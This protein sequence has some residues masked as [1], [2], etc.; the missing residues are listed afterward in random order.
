MDPQYLDALVF[1][2]TL[3][4]TLA[5]LG[6]GDPPAAWM[7]EYA[8]VSPEAFDSTISTG[9]NA[10]GGSVSMVLN[11]R[12]SLK[13]RALHAVRA[14]LDS[15]YVNPYTVTASEPFPPRRSGFVVRLA[16]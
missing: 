15:G 11:F 9:V 3:F 6:A 12:Q 14:E 8:K 5:S 10:E 16:P 2:R 1:Y 7:A 13:V 4:P